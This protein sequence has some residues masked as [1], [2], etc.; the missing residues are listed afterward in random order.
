MTKAQLTELI[1]KEDV[2]IF[3]VIDIVLEING[4][5]GVGKIRLSDDI[6]NYINSNEKQDWN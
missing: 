3:K 6:T 4:I 5:I 2:T 1:K